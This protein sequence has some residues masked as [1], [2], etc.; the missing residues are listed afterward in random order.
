M[1]AIVFIDGQNLYFGL[2]NAFSLGAKYPTYDPKLIG[3]HAC[4]LVSPLVE[5]DVTLEETRFYTGIPR[6]TPE[7][8]TRYKFWQRKLDKAKHDNVTV[9]TRTLQYTPMPD[10][11]FIRRE[12]GIDVRIAIDI[13]MLAITNKYDLA[14]LFSQDG[15]FGEVALE[16]SRISQGNERF[17][18]LKTISCYPLSENLEKR[19]FEAKNWIGKPFDRSFYERCRE[20]ENFFEPRKK[21]AI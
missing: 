13:L 1:R 17:S 9:I 3:I 10:G 7:E 18:H 20:H 5:G 4:E 11:G 2:N 21:L 19:Q 16:I 6:D 8:E 14:I 12:K 15:D